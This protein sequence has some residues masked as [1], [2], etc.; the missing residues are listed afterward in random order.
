MQTRPRCVVYLFHSFVYVVSLDL[1]LIV[2][3]CPLRSPC[4]CTLAGL[5]VRLFRWEATSRSV[6]SGALA[7]NGG[8]LG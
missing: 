1:Q 4:S 3:S 8:R 7:C 2:T 5:H 6:R